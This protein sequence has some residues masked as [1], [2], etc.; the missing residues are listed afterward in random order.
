[1]NKTNHIDGPLKAIHKLRD[2]LTPH[3]IQILEIRRAVRDDRMV[4]EDEYALLTLLIQ[5]P[6]PS[7]G[8]PT[9]DRSKEN[10]LT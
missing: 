10:V 7:W 1:M 3:D 2:I 9:T 5:M 4:A 8:V 6:V